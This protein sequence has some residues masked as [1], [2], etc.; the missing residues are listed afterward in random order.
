MMLPAFRRMLM[1]CSLL[2]MYSSATAQLANR[3]DV[4][5]DELFPDPGP[6]VQLPNAEFIELKNV[7]TTAFNIRN[8]KLSDGSTTATIATNFILQ[9]DS[10]VI[11]CAT[12]A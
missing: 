4:V 7:S 2:L 6:P 1:A 8:W 5:I 12:S 9:P 11:I 3:F 10:F